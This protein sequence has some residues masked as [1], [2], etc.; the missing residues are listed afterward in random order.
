[1]IM[2]AGKRWEA[3]VDHDPRSERVY[4]IVS[5]GDWNHTNDATCWK[6][7]GDGDN[8]EGL[9]FALDV[10][11]EEMD[12]GNPAIARA[13]R[14]ERDLA[15]W[16]GKAAIAVK[17]LARIREL[18]QAGHVWHARWQSAANDANAFA[19]ELSMADDIRAEH[20]AIIAEMP[21]IIDPTEDAP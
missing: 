17:H 20:L 10:L 15:E 9:M 11:F 12:G 6:R 21:A 4:A 8:G 19:K 2:D 14:A 16:Q 5:R 18:E 1:M 3:G 13:E 7:G